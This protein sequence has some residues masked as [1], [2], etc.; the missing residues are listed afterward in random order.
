MSNFIQVN[1]K[2]AIASDTRQW[3]VQKSS[4]AKDKD[5]GDISTQWNS[6]SFNGTLSQAVKELGEHMLRT[7]GSS[8]YT[9]LVQAATDIND[10]LSQSFTGQADIKFIE[11]L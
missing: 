11:Q 2:Y 7:G 3:M 1:N 9:E 6:I 10:L 5:T 4:Q 8:S